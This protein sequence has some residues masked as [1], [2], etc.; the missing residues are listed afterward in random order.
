VDD[1][2]K[3]R[4]VRV[5]LGEVETA[6]RACAGVRGAVV[7]AAADPSGSG[8]RLGGYVVAAPALAAIAGAG[9]AAVTAA[10]VPGAAGGLGALPLRAKGR[11]DEAGLA[12]AATGRRAVGAREAVAPRTA[13]EEALA[14]IWGAVLGLGEGGVSIAANFFALGGHSL[15][16]G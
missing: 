8:Q 1:Q 3:V 11:G 7:V 16:A 14:A 2:V 12:R 13:T 5:E 6:L 10:A 15:S 9:A 4:G